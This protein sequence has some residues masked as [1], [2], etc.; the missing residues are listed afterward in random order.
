[1]ERRPESES[2]ALPAKLGGRPHS[3]CGPGAPPP[4]R[5]PVEE[6]PCEDG[7]D[8]DAEDSEQLEH[9]LR[10][11]EPRHPDDARGSG[12]QDLTMTG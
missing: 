12:W 2:E 9:A 11:P 5:V 6:V 8:H 3:G 4:R 7:H 1:M 10:L